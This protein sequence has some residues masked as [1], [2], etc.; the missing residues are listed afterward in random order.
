MYP[1]GRNHRTCNPSWRCYDNWPYTQNDGWMGYATQN[2]NHPNAT[3]AWREIRKAVLTFRNNKQA[4]DN[5]YGNAFVRLLDMGATYTPFINNA[6]GFR[7]TGWECK[8]WVAGDG[9]N[10]AD[11]RYCNTWC[12]SKRGGCPKLYMQAP[13]FCR[14][15]T[16]PWKATASMLYPDA[17]T[18]DINGGIVTPSG[19]TDAAGRKLL[20]NSRNTTM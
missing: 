14:C 5:A 16:A 3:K 18:Q 11:N 10:K 19:P 7:I 4:W 6:R 9:N 12:S 17:L 20:M 1:T 8:F 13:R 15:V 2:P